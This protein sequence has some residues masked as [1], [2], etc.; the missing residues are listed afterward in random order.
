M[1]P[2]FT[3]LSSSWLS[4]PCCS[5]EPPWYPFYLQDAKDSFHLFPFTF[6]SSSFFHIPSSS[7]NFFLGITFWNH[8]TTIM[9]ADTRMNTNPYLRGKPS[10]PSMMMDDR[11][12]SHSSSNGG[13]TSP[14]SY[15][16]QREMSTTAMLLTREQQ[17]REEIARLRKEEQ[18]LREKDHWIKQNILAVREKLAGSDRRI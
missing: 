17:L 7:S 4:S 9:M 13:S 3:L 16:Q 2:S 18:E 6:C 8:F 14:S 1:L 5:C 10:K 11:S 12:S 15:H